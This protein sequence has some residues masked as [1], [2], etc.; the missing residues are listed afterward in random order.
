MLCAILGGYW[1]TDE[2]LPRGALGRSLRSLRDFVPD[3]T[4]LTSAAL[5]ESPPLVHLATL[6]AFVAL[7]DPAD[8]AN[9]PVL[10]ELTEFA[11]RH[12][13]WPLAQRNLFALQ[14]PS[15][16]RYEALRARGARSADL[17]RWALSA[18]TQARDRAAGE[19]AAKRGFA[20]LAR[21]PLDRARLL[22]DLSNLY[23][24]LGDVACARSALAAADRLPGFASRR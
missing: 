3:R 21:R 24:G 18:A 15:L 5:S 17:E 1:V 12:P 20:I 13:K 19:L 9:I 16:E 14:P 23:R 22:A 8:P 4:A 6:S 7:R 11:L 2:S 10:S